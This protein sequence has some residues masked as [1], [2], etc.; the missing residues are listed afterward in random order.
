[1]CLQD[2]NFSKSSFRFI[3]IVCMCLSFST[4]TTIQAAIITLEQRIASSSDDAEEKKSGQVNLTST[5]LEL[6]IDQGVQQVGLRFPGLDIPRG[7]V[8]QKA[9]IQFQSDNTKSQDGSLSIYGELSHNAE[10]FTTSQYN[11]SNRATTSASVTWAPPAWVRKQAEGLDQ[12]TTDITPVIQKIV[13]QDGWSNNHAL[14]IIIKGTSSKRVAES[15]DG[16]P[17]GA[18][19]LHIEY[20]DD[21]PPVVEPSFTNWHDLELTFNDIGV[22][23]DSTNKLLLLPL[24]T[25]FNTPQSYSSIIEYKLENQGFSIGMDHASPI[26]SGSTHTLDNI[27]YGSV[28]P[29]QLYQNSQL[30][31][32][33]T[34]VFT[35]LAVI[36]LSADIIVDE[37]KNPGTFRLLSGEFSQATGVMNMGIEFRGSTSQAYPKKSFS[38]ELVKA[39]TPEDELKIKLLNLRKDGDWILDASYIDTTLVRNRISH[40][41]Y[42]EMRPFA[43]TNANGE[44]TGQS[45]VEGQLVEVILNQ[46]YHGVYVLSEKID[47][48]LLGLKKIKVP[49]AADETKLWSQVDF[50]LP[51]NGTVL[52]KASSNNANL[53]NPAGV[54]IDFEQKYPKLTDIARWEPLEQ[55]ADFIAHA[56]DADFRDGIDSRVDIDSVVDYWILTLIT[57]NKDT[58]K[59][60]YYLARNESDKFFIVP[61]DYDATFSLLWNGTPFQTVKWWPPGK[62]NLIRR[63]FEL[64]ETGFNCKVKTRWQALRNTILTEPALTSRF[65]RYMSQLRPM[66]GEQENPAIRNSDRWPESGALG[67]NNPELGQINHISNWIQGRLTYLDNQISV[68]CNN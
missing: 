31:D 60:N 48:K 25:G 28:I 54:R 17:Q 34:L 67:I 37:P 52:Y 1:M 68:S 44:A 51:E 5:D 63:L 47:R 21:P 66:I 27:H 49:T 50:S 29:V 39:D 7:A 18:P 24:A 2:K 9:Y 56:S 12:R 15:F 58:L 13:N 35:N 40:D 14:V 8:I 61:W 10:T 57:S 46:T 55:L 53:H 36:E 30:I 6:I 19:L 42:R 64:T 38:L 32:N 45:T 65:E 3:T 4:V 16:R 23:V 62:N 22:G 43:Y 26:A 33:Y 41:I 20:A 59:K 11:I